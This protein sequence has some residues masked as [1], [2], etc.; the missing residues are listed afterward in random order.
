MKEGKDE[1]II[2]IP[3]RLLRL[4]SKDKLNVVV[5]DDRVVIEKA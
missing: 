3:K 5:E 1:V 4:E 2:R